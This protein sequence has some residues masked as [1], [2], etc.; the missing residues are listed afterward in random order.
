[1]AELGLASLL[2]VVYWPSRQISYYLRH[3]RGVVTTIRVPGLA[4][5]IQTARDWTFHSQLRETGHATMPYGQIQ[6][7]AYTIS[8]ELTEQVTTPELSTNPNVCFTAL[9]RHLIVCNYSVVR[10][11]FVSLFL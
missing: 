10:Q 2:K 4:P 9:I 6:E 3:F 11:P 8:C 5:S 1:M 7:L